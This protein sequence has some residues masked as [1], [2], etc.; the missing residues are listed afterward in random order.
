M[1]HSMSSGDVV[2]DCLFV[3][4]TRRGLMSYGRRPAAFSTVVHVF[5]I[6]SPRYPLGAPTRRLGAVIII[7]SRIYRYILYIYGLSKQICNDPTDREGKR[8]RETDTGS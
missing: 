6:A 1:N 4:A 5:S 7:S 8:N 2:I 3:G